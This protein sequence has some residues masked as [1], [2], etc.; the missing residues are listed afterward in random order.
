[1]KKL[2]LVLALLL[3]LSLLAGCSPSVQ[4]ESA[5]L[6]QSVA[7]E[8]PT[9]TETESESI[10]IFADVEPA[11][12]PEVPEELF[13]QPLDYGRYQDA[14]YDY[15]PQPRTLKELYNYKHVG[16]IILC[17]IVSD[18]E[19]YAYVEEDRNHIYVD[20][21]VVRVIKGN[22][23]VGDMLTITEPGVWGD[24][25]S[26]VSPHG[27]PLLRKGMRVLLFTMQNLLE[28]APEIER[29]IKIKEGYKYTGLG[30][31]PYLAK[32][33]IDEN[34]MAYPAYSYMSAVSEYPIFWECLDDFKKPVP[35]G[36]LI[37]VLESYAE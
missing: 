24:N 28:T 26:D 34:N 17:D 8:A 21:K 7:T 29:P 27:I 20:V 13:F 23:E 3:V 1:M 35:L 31:A 5:A 9:E 19:E 4:D 15:P 33:Y 11:E 36:Q 16:Y 30:A 14:I 25:G 18:A 2:S 37:A 22:L 10:D 6:S 32:I 12:V